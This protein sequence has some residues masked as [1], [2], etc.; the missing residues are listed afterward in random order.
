MQ[1]SIYDGENK[2][3]VDPNRL[4]GSEESDIKKKKRMKED[5]S[6]NKTKF[7]YNNPNPLRELSGT[8]TQNK[9]KNVAQP[10]IQQKSM[11]FNSF[12]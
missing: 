6:V 5:R 1:Y 10:K 4:Y 11:R 8:S 7:V 9:Q 3:N 12:R 2:E